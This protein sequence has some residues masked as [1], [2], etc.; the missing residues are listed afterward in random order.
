MARTA[1]DAL[2]H[3]VIT[4]KINE[5]KRGKWSQ[6]YVS[7]DKVSANVTKADAVWLNLIPRACRGQ[8]WVNL[9]LSLQPLFAFCLFTNTVVLLLTAPLISRHQ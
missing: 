2:R 7:A 8:K 5:V 4:E 1:L 3:G 6:R 9:S